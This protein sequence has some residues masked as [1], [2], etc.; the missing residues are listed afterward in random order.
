MSCCIIAKLSDYLEH[1]R[2][3]R[4]HLDD[5]SRIKAQLLVVVKDCVH[6]FNPDSV[7]GSV[8]HDPLAVRCRAGGG[9][10][11]HRRH[12]AIL[13]FVGVGVELSVHLTHGNRLGIELHSCKEQ[14][15]EDR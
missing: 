8:E 10:A 3:L 1:H 5:L 2:H 7:D 12:D 13:P 4:A 11:V 6:V 9:Q 15:L 14:R